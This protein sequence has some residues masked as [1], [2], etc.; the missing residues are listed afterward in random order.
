MTIKQWSGNVVEHT[1]EGHTDSVRALC[2][3]PGLGFVSGSHDMTLRAWT[4][5]GDCLAT[6]VGHTALIYACAATST[7]LASGAPK[8]ATFAVP[9]SSASRVFM[10]CLIHV[11]AQP[12]SVSQC[13]LFYGTQRS[14][15][16]LWAPCCWHLG[17]Q[18]PKHKHAGE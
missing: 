14:G 1:Y 7:A 8:P 4:L 2:E 15:S 5:A 6:L 11:V 3:A 16:C 9:Q 13:S 17:C 18:H 10:M 12:R